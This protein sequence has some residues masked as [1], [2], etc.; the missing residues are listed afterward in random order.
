M[1][2]LVLG[3]AGFIGR[4][5]VNLLAD[6]GEEVTCFDINPPGS[7]FEHHGSQ[8]RVVR[9]DVSSF[10]DVLEATVSTRPSCILNLAF[11]LGE[12]VPHRA[13]KINIVGMDNC[14]EIARICEVERV[15]YGSSVTVSGAQ[16]RYGN[17]SIDET[18]ETHGQ[19]QYAKHKMFNEW[20]ARDYSDKYGMSITG[21]RPAHVTGSD[22]VLGSVDHVQCITQPALGRPV[23]LGY[24]DL[25]RCLIHVDDVAEI[26]KVVTL[27]EST[28]H[29]LY[30]SG[31]NPTSLGELADLVR[32]FLPEAEIEFDSEEGG[33]AA[34][35]NYL[36]DN[37]RLVQE[38]GL[39]FRPTRD[40]VAAIINETREQAGP[41]P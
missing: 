5:I 22:K 37:S 26:F 18:E 27:A 16:T 17:R 36:V 29:D 33:S 9:G 30:N 38:F 40:I 24:K 21:V 14:L 23:R 4:R 13:F 25:V 12:N 7:A 3:G 6:A 35:V 8:V 11:M 28:A 15:V 20:H 41:V 2:I 39:S 1:S 10:D 34:S 19:G 32:E 31:G